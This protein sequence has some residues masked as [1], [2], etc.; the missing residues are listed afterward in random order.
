[1]LKGKIPQT[2]LRLI[3]GVKKEDLI[4]RDPGYFVQEVFN[5]INSPVRLIVEM[6]PDKVAESRVKK[7]RKEAEKKGRQ[8]SDAYKSYAAFNL[9]ITNV[10]QDNLPV[11]SVIKLYHIR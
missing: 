11:D 6:L 8:L 2:Q 7:A 3:A 4:I 9:F 1:M 10:D 5:Q